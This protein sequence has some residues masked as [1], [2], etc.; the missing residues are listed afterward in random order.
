MNDRVIRKERLL[1]LI[2]ALLES[3]EVIAP[4]SNLSFERIDSGSQVLLDLHNTVKSPK[5]AFFAAREVLCA[6]KVDREGVSV[7]DVELE[8]DKPR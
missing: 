5:E 6:F 7:T 8:Q 3:H 4:R 2:D 1:E